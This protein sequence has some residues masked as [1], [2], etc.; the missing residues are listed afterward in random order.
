MYYLRASEEDV[1]VKTEALKKFYECD[2][3]R[4]LLNDYA[5]NDLLSLLEFWEAI[6]DEDEK[7]FSESVLKK[8]YV[9]KCAP[10]SMWENMTSVYYLAFRDNEDNLNND[11][12]EQFLSKITAFIFAYA[13]TNPGVTALRRVVYKEIPK[14]QSHQPCDFKEFI[15][16]LEHIRGALENYKF[17]NSRAVTR[18]LLTWYAFTFNE[19]E[20]PKGDI[21]FDIEHIY[22]K[23]RH[24]KEGKLK[25]PDNLEELGNKILLERSIN[26]SASDYRFCDKKRYYLGGIDAKGKRREKSMIAEYD[27]LTQKDD[28]TEEDIINRDQQIIAKFIGFLEQEKLLKIANDKAPTS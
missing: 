13:L 14:I 2:D 4:R 16:S 15:F 21:V 3:Y 23:A 20:R 6:Y 27:H 28:F 19:Q 8:L 7:R 10:N 18:S 5:I 11:E 25:N 26:I 12:F 17:T 24:Q 1:P 22:A 9:L